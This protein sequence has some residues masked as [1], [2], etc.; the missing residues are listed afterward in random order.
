[1]DFLVERYKQQENSKSF[2]WNGPP[3]LRFV[4]VRDDAVLNPVPAGLWAVSEIIAFPIG[5]SDQGWKS[6]FKSV[7]DKWLKLGGKPH[8]GKFWGFEED[9]RGTVQP[10]HPKQACKIYSDAQKTAFDDFRKQV[11]PDGL[12]AA[13]SAMLLLTPCEDFLI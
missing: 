11:D 9:S 7:Q 2:E 12:F 5:E 3:E 6:A 13:G 8:I 1:M 10:Y 4:T